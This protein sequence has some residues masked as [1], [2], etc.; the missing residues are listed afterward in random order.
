MLRCSFFTLLCFLL[1][2]SIQAQTLDINVN[3][4]TAE[5]MFRGVVT[6]KVYGCAELNARFLYGSDNHDNDKLGSIGVDAYGE[7]DVIPG[8]EVGVGAKLY[9]AGID[10]DEVLTVGLGGLL[11]Y[12]PPPLR[13][14]VLSGTIYYSPR[15]L[16]FLDAERLLEMGFRIGYPIISNAHVYLGYRNIRT[17][18]EDHGEPRIGEG[19]HAGVEFFF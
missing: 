2:A 18:L 7:S 12:A 8:M 6:E 11:R 3:D 19:A 13:G 1:S 5:V 16:S 17:H 4:D 10:H 9:G 15:I 14:F